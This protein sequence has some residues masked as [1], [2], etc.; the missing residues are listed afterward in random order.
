MSIEKKLL[1]DL[2]DEL[3]NQSYYFN[4][5]AHDTLKEKNPLRE[6]AL[7]LSKAL[8]RLSLKVVT[9]KEHLEDEGLLGDGPLAALR[10]EAR[11]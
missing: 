8:L 3:V 4:D 2:S 6:E 10:T 5:R 7:Y 1:D 11:L 9:F